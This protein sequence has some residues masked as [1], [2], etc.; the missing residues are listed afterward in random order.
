MLNHEFDFSRMSITYEFLE[1]CKTTM[2]DM[3]KKD[4]LHKSSVAFNECIA[5]HSKQ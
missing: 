5:Y 4:F 1:K 3:S 2:K